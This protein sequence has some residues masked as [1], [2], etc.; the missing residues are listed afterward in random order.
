MSAA[1]IDKNH[2]VWMD[3]EMTGLDP[4]QDT[5][6]EI[7]TIITDSQL[8]IIAEGPVFAIHHDQQALDAM[9]EWCVRQHGESGLSKRVLDST[10]TLA[11]AEA[12]TLDFIRQYVPECSSPLCGNSIHQDRRF[13]VRYMPALEA[14]VHY[15]NIDVSTVKELASRWYPGLKAPAKNGS[16]LAMDDVRDSIAE[17]KFYREKLFIP[18]L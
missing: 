5:I 17:L 8:N 11:E 4:E 13:L 3:L 14:W 7:A 12:A 15:R 6:L 10:T 1:Q 16:H 2:L 9:N 18:S